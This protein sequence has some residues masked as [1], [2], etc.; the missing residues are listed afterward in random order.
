MGRGSKIGWETRRIAWMHIAI[1]EEQIADDQWEEKEKIGHIF[2]SCLV[3]VIRVGK[4]QHQK[5]WPWK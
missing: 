5:E 3:E 1:A 4:G 2:N